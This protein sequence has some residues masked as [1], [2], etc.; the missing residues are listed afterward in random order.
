MIEKLVIAGIYG[1][2]ILGLV[3]IYQAMTFIWAHCYCGAGIGDDMTNEIPTLLSSDTGLSQ[4]QKFICFVFGHDYR[5]S[6]NYEHFYECTRCGD[7][8]RYV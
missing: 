6:N 3:Y 4:W 1:A 8:S 5:T 2:G 7:H